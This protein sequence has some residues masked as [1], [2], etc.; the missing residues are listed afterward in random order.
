MLLAD[1]LAAVVS[2]WVL[3]EVLELTLVELALAEVAKE[4]FAER[5]LHRL[6][7]CR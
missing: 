1:I 6:I 2:F 4:E 5:L 7:V 3:F